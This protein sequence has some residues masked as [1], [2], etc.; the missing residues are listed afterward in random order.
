[1]SGWLCPHLFHEGLT[2]HSV[3]RN[4]TA[5]P[6]CIE[7]STSIYV[8]S[9]CLLWLP[10]KQGG[11]RTH[12]RQGA[13]DLLGFE[14][15]KAGNQLSFAFNYIFSWAT[16]LMGW[17]KVQRKSR[18]SKKLE[19]LANRPLAPGTCQITLLHSCSP[20]SDRWYQHQFQDCG[21]WKQGSTIYWSTTMCPALGGACA[22]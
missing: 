20:S 2:A 9:S 3:L 22:K 12:W 15:D 17:L 18:S 6:S 7:F 13:W 5:C 11:L 19:H 21:K 16:I 14:N 4:P 10:L 1:M 8:M